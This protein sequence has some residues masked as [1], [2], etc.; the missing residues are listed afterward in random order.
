ML[1][2]VLLALTPA[3]SPP[4]FFC[5]FSFGK[6]SKFSQVNIPKRCQTNSGSGRGCV[7][8]TCVCR[9]RV[10]GQSRETL[11]WTGGGVSSRCCLLNFSVNTHNISLT[12][13]S[14]GR[15]LPGFS[16]GLAAHAGS[17]LQDPQ[18]VNEIFFTSVSKETSP[19]L[20]GAAAISRAE[21]SAREQGCLQRLPPMP[22]FLSFPRLPYTLPF[23]Y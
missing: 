1:G 7:G 18:R 8:R 3:H 23:V 20:Q 22:L 13:P 10:A 5:F 4:P 14:C 19:D 17:A 16:R 6:K 11:S 12:R 21:I 15:V 9:N 2:S